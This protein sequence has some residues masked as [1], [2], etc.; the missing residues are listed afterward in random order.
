MR[1]PVMTA[2][3]AWLAY[4]ATHAVTIFSI[5]WLPAAIMVAVNFAVMPQMLEAQIALAGV[6]ESD[7]P[8]AVLEALG[9]VMR[10][11][12]ISYA[13][14]ALAYPMMYAGLLRHVIRGD[15]PR[16]PFYLR[17]ATDEA[18]I[19]GGFI[20]L[21]IM[22]TII[23]VAFLLGFLVLGLLGGLAGEAAGGIAVLVAG[24]AGLAAMAWFAVKTSLV[25]PAAIGT[26]TIG[27]AQSWRE[28]NGAEWGLFFYW[29]IWVGAIIV[30]GVILG[31]VFAAG[32]FGMLVELFQ[33]A[34]DEAAAAEIERRMLEWQIEQYDLSKPGG[35]LFA[36]LNFLGFVVGTAVS[37]APAGVAWRYLKGEAGGSAAA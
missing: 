18:H 15:A 33:S 24:L 14:A 32:Y 27:L 4:L 11:A 2:S 20:I 28:T 6:E 1:F 22:W 8:A 31:V 34:G 37:V 29:L 26:R 16:L 23:A 10:T 25:F 3:G 7:D 12:G 9:P 19:L 36:I 21:M 17:F 35:W 30:L 5:L 13:V